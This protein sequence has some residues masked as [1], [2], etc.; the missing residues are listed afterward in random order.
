MDPGV[1]DRRVGQFPGRVVDRQHRQPVAVAVA[2]LDTG[3]AFDDDQAQPRGQVPAVF[4]PNPAASGPV[5]SANG[6]NRH[7]RSGASS[8]T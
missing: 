5:A 7:G 2:Q 4:S 8:S 1:R 3:A 6:V